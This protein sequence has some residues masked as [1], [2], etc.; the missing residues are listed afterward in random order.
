MRGIDPDSL[1]LQHSPLAS[2]PGTPGRSRNGT[3]GYALSVDLGQLDRAHTSFAASIFSSLD[4]T[5]STL[6][7]LSALHK[8]RY[9][10]TAAAQEHDMPEPTTSATDAAPAAVEDEPIR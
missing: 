8:I 6:C 5:N 4:D 2:S 10:T 3:I 1:S 9:P 7:L